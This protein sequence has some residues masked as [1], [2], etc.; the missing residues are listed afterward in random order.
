MFAKVVLTGI[1]V[2]A[3]ALAQGP[4]GGGGGGAGGGGRGGGM[5][6][7][8]MSGGGV[9]AS[10]HK[11]SQADQIANRLKLTSDQKSEVNS[12][13]EAT[14]RDAAPIVQQVLKCRQDLANALL[15]G[16]S[17]AEIAPLNQALSDAVFQMTGVEV[18]AFQKV[19]ALLKPN[20]MSKAPEAFDLMT[21]IFVQQT[22]ARGG[23]EGR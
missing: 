20:Q 17:E 11:E 1:A 7:P 5:G 3:L 4:G 12:L 13:F 8:G 6:D 18:K 10:Y 16:K 21:D 14:T 9:R 22:R 19:I 23:S 15:K 2:A